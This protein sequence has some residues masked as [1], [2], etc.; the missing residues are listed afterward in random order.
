MGFRKLGDFNIPLLAKQV[1]RLHTEPNSFWAQMIKG[2]YYPH[3]DVLH[4]GKGSR[5]SWAWNN[6]L[7]GKTLIDEGARWPVGNGNS[8]DIWRDKWIINSEVGF[9]RPTIPHSAPI[10]MSYLIDW[11]SFSWLGLT[12]RHGNY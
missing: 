1:W 8:I 12:F 3:T 5:A 11:E 10:R 6:L 7:E 2:I 9:I 4:A